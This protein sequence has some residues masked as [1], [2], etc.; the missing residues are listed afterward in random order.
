LKK[1]T[2]AI[3]LTHGL[4]LAGYRTILVD[5]DSQEHIVFA[6]GMDKDPSLYRLVVEDEKIPDVA[7]FNQ[8]FLDIVPGDNRKKQEHNRRLQLPH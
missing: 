3:T 8:E 6:L 5:L 1:T 4:A 7:V 2:T